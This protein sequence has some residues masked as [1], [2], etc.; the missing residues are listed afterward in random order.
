VADLAG[1][2]DRG[3][4]ALEAAVV[5]AA[6]RGVSALWLQVLDGNSGAIALYRSFGFAPAGGYRYLVAPE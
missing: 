1:L 5:V 4:P 2:A 3:W 6:E